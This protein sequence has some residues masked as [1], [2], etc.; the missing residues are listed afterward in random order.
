MCMCVH[1]KTP[2]LP[3]RY[4]WRLSDVCMFCHPHE[5]LYTLT[6]YF[7]Q[8]STDIFWPPWIYIVLSCKRAWPCNV[9]YYFCR[10]ILPRMWHV[11][12]YI[13]K[14]IYYFLGCFMC[15][16]VGPLGSWALNL[17]YTLTPYLCV[18]F[19]I[20]SD[21][22][23]LCVYISL[24]ILT[25]HVH[26]C[27]FHCTFWHHMCVCEPFPMY[28]ETQHMRVYISLWTLTPTYVCVPVTIHTNALHIVCVHFTQYS[29]TKHLCV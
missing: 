6:S 19:T 16:Y 27:T 23:P 22:L 20:H 5:H 9:A 8:M 28:S 12:L 7:T 11:Q 2:N 4:I 13:L 29:N 21:T 1:P 14:N 26:V 18:H 25:L 17:L 15:V 3:S 10:K 24:Y